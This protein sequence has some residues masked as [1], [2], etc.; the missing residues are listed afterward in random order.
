MHFCSDF[1]SVVQRREFS[2]VKHLRHI[3]VIC[4]GPSL[5]KEANAYASA[6]HGLGNLQVGTTEATSTEAKRYIYCQGE[7]HVI[8]AIK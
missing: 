3:N 7:F 4:F 2:H 5:I 6:E 1:V 8:Y